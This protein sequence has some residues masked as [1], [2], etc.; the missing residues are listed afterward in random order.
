MTID[1]ASGTVS[2]RKLRATKL[3]AVFGWLPDASGLAGLADAGFVSVRVPEG[4]VHPIASAVDNL[5]GPQLIDPSTVVALTYDEYINLWTLDTTTGALNRITMSANKHEG[6]GGLAWTADGRIVFTARISARGERVRAAL[7]I[8]NADGSGRRQLTR[9]TE[10]TTHWN[11]KV[12]PVAPMVVYTEI[13]LKNQTSRLMQIHL[14][15]TNSSHIEGGD[16]GSG[17]SFTPDGRS[18]VFIRRK[19]GKPQAWRVPMEGGEPTLIADDCA[20]ND[21]DPS[22]KWLLCCTSKAEEYVIPLA[23]GTPTWRRDVPANYRMSWTPDGKYLSYAEPP[24]RNNFLGNIWLQPV[25]DAPAKRLT[26]FTTSAIWNFA[27]SPDGKRLVMSREIAQRD[28]VLLT[29]VPFSTKR[30]RS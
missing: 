6:Q 9:P 10:E 24:P 21:V 7:W 26:N 12:S 3:L 18:I 30:P 28:A 22:G 17:P 8:C 13:N 5:M 25:S 1:A 14:D 20:A 2:R 29:N 19:E 15:G 23:G 27:W 4:T 16:G 11:L